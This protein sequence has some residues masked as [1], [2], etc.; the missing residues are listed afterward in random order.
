[1][2]LNPFQQ[3]ISD[4]ARRLG[5]RGSA[6]QQVY[7]R[8]EYQQLVNQF[9]GN[10]P[11]PAGI[12]PSMV[13]SQS[14]SSLEYTDPQGYIHQLIRELSGVS[15]RLGEVREAST[16]R[17]AVLPLG[18]QQQEQIT[19]LSQQLNTIF[20]NPVALSQLDPATLQL[21]ATMKQ[22]EDQALQ[23]QFDR[24]IGTVIAQLTGQGVGAS[25][26]ASDTLARA[27]QSQ[28]LVKSQAQGQQAQRQLGVQQF[29]TGQQGQ[30]NINMQQFLQQLLGLGTQRDISGA[31]IG[32]GKE[33]LTSQNDQFFRGLQEQMRQFDEQMRMQER[34]NL[35]NN[36]FKGIATGA[37]LIA[38]PLTGGFSSLFSGAGGALAPGA[39]AQ[40]AFGGFRGF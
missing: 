10:I 9:F 35:L 8:P 23:E 33:Q 32:L 22:A 25:S 34:Q 6:E 36:I 21:L 12:D 39:A 13:T 2:G 5:L 14:G 24:E 3:Q 37:S 7:Q 26:I 11:L 28:G 15:P 38:G 30:Q 31:Q 29:L 16:N 18:G 4:L 17:P 40:Q 20:S 19:N 27:K 1:M